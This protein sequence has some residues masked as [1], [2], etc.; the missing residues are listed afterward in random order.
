M[1]GVAAVEQFSVTGDGVS[2]MNMSAISSMAILDTKTN[3]QGFA[4]TRVRLHGSDDENDILV[5]YE[6]IGGPRERQPLAIA[7]WSTEGKFVSRRVIDCARID[8]SPVRHWDDGRLE[9]LEKREKALQT[10]TL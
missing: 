9:R 8:F 1:G 7:G 6:V 4:K 10:E 2:K 3:N 5:Q